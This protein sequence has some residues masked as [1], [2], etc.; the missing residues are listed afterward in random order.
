M[1]EWRFDDTVFREDVLKPV[2]D[3]WPPKDDL[4]RV[5]LLP[6]DVADERTITAALAGINSQFTNQRYRGF[7]RAC[8]SLRA[9]HQAATV[10]L[11]DPA[12]R[13]SH[14][15]RID[16]LSAKLTESLRQRLNGAPGLPSAEV[17]A[18]VK[19]SK[20]TLTRTA[21]R[22]ALVRA[23]GAE[24]DPAEL[25][26]LVEP[27]QWIETRGLLSQLQ[28]DS[29][30]SY[31]ATVLNGPST[32]TT[33]IGRRRDELRV[34]RAA[35]AVAE[36][37][38]L[39]RAQLWID[40]G[41]LVAALRYEVFDD[42][43][44]KVNFGYQ[45]V[46][47][48]A[49]AAG[50][51]LRQLGL[52]ADPALVAYAVWCARPGNGGNRA[53]GWQDDYQQSISELRLRAAVAVLDA[54]PNLPKEWAERRDK[55]VKQL[56]ALDA[57]VV[58][59]RAL[60]STDVEAAVEGYRRI[61]EQLADPDV[62]AAIERC[63][64]AEPRSAAGRV[65]DGQVVISW[66]PSTSRVGRIEYRVTRGSTVVCAE[67]GV[68]EAVDASPPGG[69][70]LVYSVHTLRDGNPSARAARTAEVTMLAEVAGL[71]LHG[72]PAAISGRWTLPDGAVG[73]TVSRDGKP[74]PGAGLT[75]FVDRQV[76]PGV[77]YQY[78][79]RARYR[80]SAGAAGYSDGLSATSS[81]QEVPVAVT[82]FTAEF[83]EGELVASWKP[84]PSGEVQVLEFAAGDQLPAPDVMPAA[85]AMRNGRPVRPGT[86]G[87]PGQLRARSVT[88]G[89]RVVLLPVTVLGELA[90]VGT[91]YAVDVRHSPV[92]GLR[93]RRL[94][95]TVELTWEWPAGATVA[96]VVWRSA[97][98][99]SG[100]T[101]PDAAFRDVTKV[102]HD[103]K[104]VTIP[105][106]EGD[107]W[108]GVCT[109]IRDDKEDSFGPLV[110][111][112]GSMT[113]TARYTVDRVRRRGPWVLTVEAEH[114]QELP[115]MTLRAKAGVRPTGPHDGM[116][117]E[118]I[119]AGPSPIRVEFRVPPELRRPVHLK[120]CS[121]DDGVVLVAS[122]PDQ[123]IVR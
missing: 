82:D 111:T 69:T 67:T 32:T 54:Q 3:G 66:S 29:L 122:R 94:G 55:L 48:G 25:P 101:D 27:V 105:V 61:R 14:R 30:W 110:L 100:P 104:G 63:R 58:R 13:K 112:G 2:Q 42:L 59:C 12:R 51:R 24:L 53:P 44:A 75:T 7:R 91:P 92:R 34:S 85:R 109:V 1:S 4:F 113:A 37:A 62:I 86:P 73:A 90:A 26:A 50:G 89:N 121:L 118:S 56:S 106:P 99:P 93:L 16:E 21:V 6:T 116:E 49:K 40:A 52:P 36:T 74:V 78:L 39:K 98:K 47:A 70:A 20:G 71:E 76:R 9:Q 15:Q 72:G 81:C 31:L 96:R 10:V 68:C 22:A 84:P 35:E 8:E 103:S 120:A 79:I 64:P 23:G 43:R 115:P 95:S 46:A 45:D 77:T 83:Q 119:K 123:L 80:L 87:G 60:E 5:Y 108:F 88:A 114:G 117:L 11:T 41:E 107:Y 18:L 38:V 19:S 33:E 57:E 17:A 97:A 65:T 28:H 102:T